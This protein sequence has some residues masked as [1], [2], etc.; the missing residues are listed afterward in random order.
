[1]LAENTVSVVRDKERSRNRK[2]ISL[3][4]V[5]V[6]MSEWMMRKERLKRERAFVSFAI[7]SF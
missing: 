3:V 1:M 6:C 7:Y 4:C 5:C 2:D